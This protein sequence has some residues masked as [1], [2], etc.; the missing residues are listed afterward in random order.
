LV[1]DFSPETIL[2][3]QEDRPKSFEKYFI[4]ALFAL[5]LSGGSDI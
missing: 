4:S 1:L 2:T 5:P 3:W